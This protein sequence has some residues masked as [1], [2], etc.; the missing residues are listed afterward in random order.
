MYLSAQ[1]LYYFVP[2]RDYGYLNDRTNLTPKY[3][4][5]PGGFDANGYFAKHAESEK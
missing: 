4:K 3:T 1:R 5:N 2:Q